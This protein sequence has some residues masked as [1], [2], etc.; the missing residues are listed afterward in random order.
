MRADDWLDPRWQASARDWITSTSA[1]LGT[2]VTGEIE[3]TRVRPWSVTLLAPT[4]AGRRWFK[5]NTPECAYEARLVSALAGWI[6]DLVL[7]PLAVDASRG[8]LLTADRGLTLRESLATAGREER[9]RAWEEML[10]AYA[11]LQRTLVPHA[12]EMVSLGVPD[13]RPARLPGVLRSLLASP[14]VRPARVVDEAEFAGWCAELAADGIPSSL[15]HDDLHDDNVFPGLRFFD[16]GDS[17]V[18]HPFGCLLVALQSASFLL[19]CSPPELLRLRDA[20]LSVWSDLAPPPAL[21][22]SAGLACRVAR[23]P[24]AAAWHRAVRDAALPVEEDF[25]TAPAEYLDELGE[26]AP[27]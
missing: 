10:R 12:A 23:V 17:A 9:L 4:S 8:W 16:W 7:A 1:A 27:I 14:D 6:P 3:Q 13:M 24:K 20:Y 18:A 26:P 25:R 2:P 19:E 22:R 21:R 11:S 15:Q 5:A